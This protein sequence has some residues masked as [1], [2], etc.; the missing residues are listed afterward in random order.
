M[1]MMISNS[2]FLSIVL[3][4]LANFDDEHGVVGLGD[5]FPMTK[6]VLGGMFAVLF[7][8]CRVLMWSRT[9]YFYCQD[10]YNTQ[11]GSDPRLK[12][13]K[14]WFQFTLFSLG[15]LTFLQIV[16]LAEIGRVAKEELEKIGL[17]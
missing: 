8:I 16:W 4:L 9:S 11:K 5:A 13:Y 12:G 7:I 17:I 10:A 15:F 3:C 2:L 1:L 14:T 6:V